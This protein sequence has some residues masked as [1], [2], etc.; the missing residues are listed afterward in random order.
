M[1]LF[2]DC[3]RSVAI[4]HAPSSHHVSLPSC[5]EHRTRALHR[6]D[7]DTYFLSLPT[8]T[9]YYDICNCKLQF[10]S[11]LSR[12]RFFKSHLGLTEIG[13][14]RGHRS[15]RRPTSDSPYRLCRSV[16]IY[17]TRRCRAREGCPRRLG[18]G[19]RGRG[20]P[21]ASWR[22]VSGGNLRPGQVYGRRFWRHWTRARGP[23][24]QARGRDP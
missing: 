6:A 21:G 7:N 8:S 24:L 13:L 20:E 17:S 19:Q 23:S 16:N 11:F 15:R 3:L 4:G 14:P 2:S 1:H 22:A 12:T 9:M 10:Q 18:G 5:T